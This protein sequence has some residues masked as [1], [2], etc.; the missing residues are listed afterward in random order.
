PRMEKSLERFYFFETSKFEFFISLLERAKVLHASRLSALG[1]MAGG[2][3]HEINSPLAIIAGVSQRL[4]RSVESG[5]IQKEKFLSDIEKIEKT[6]FR[7]AQIIKGLRYFARDA[8]L[9]PCELA[10]LNTLIEDSLTF[11]RERFSLNGIE[12]RISP[13]PQEWQLECRAV[14]IP[15]VLL[16]LLNNSFDAIQSLEEKWVSIEVSKTDRS[17]EI[18][19]TD[20]GS[21]IPVEIQ[22][23]IM[24][25]F[26]TTKEVGKG[27]GL[28]LSISKGIIESHG[29]TF[30]LVPESPHTQFKISLP[31]NI[32]Q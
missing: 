10:S 13:I 31:V 12:L 2:V 6:A 7:I 28:G 30:C 14:Q 16:N 8:A 15:Q 27:T 17:F 32:T 4:K 24:D 3:A 29:G 21:G 25:P 9:D 20:S 1:E 23:K 26:F 18:H 11:C 5:D 22:S 19:V